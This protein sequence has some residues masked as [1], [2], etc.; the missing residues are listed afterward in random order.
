[1]DSSTVLT[2]K[3]KSRLPDEFNEKATQFN[4]EFKEAKEALE[5]CVNLKHADDINFVCSKQKEKYLLGIANTFCATEYEKGVTCQKNAIE[6]YT[7]EQSKY[8]LSSADPNHWSK[9]FFDENV[10]FGK[11]CDSALRQMYIFNIEQE[12]RNPENV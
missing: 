1:M 2:R 9:K 6:S 3:R 10:L 4:A 12:L 8:S 7:N 5:K 11:C